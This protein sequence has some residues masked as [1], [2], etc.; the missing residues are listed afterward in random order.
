LQKFISHC[1]EPFQP[2]VSS[3]LVVSSTFVR[4]PPNRPLLV[5]ASGTAPLSG[6][7]HLII[8]RS[9]SQ[10][11][12]FGD[13]FQHPTCRHDGLQPATS[14]YKEQRLRDGVGGTETTLV[15]A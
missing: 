1:P 11:A 3:F 7:S 6:I 9:R 13:L 15:I 12:C 2:A 10:I 14:S 8:F 5:L 4:V